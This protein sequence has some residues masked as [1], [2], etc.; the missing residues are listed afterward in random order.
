MSKY[1]CQDIWSQ[2]AMGNGW[3]GHFA[4]VPGTYRMVGWAARVIWNM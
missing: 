1:P 4:G 2:P 3:V